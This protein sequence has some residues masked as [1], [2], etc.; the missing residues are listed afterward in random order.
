MEPYLKSHIKGRG[1][2]GFGNQMAV[3]SAAKQMAKLETSLLHL[4]QY[5]D[6]PKISL[7]INLTVSQVVKK[8]I[9]E[10]TLPEIADVGGKVED[11]TFLNSLG[12]SVKLWIREIGKVTSLDCDMSSR[13]ASQVIFKKILLLLNLISLFCF[14]QIITFWENWERALLRI[15]KKCKSPEVELT[16]NILKLDERALCSSLTQSFDT[17]TRLKEAFTKVNNYNSLMKD[18]PIQDLLSATTLDQI[19]AAVTKMLE[20]LCIR[21]PDS[22]FS[23]NETLRLVEAIS[24]DLNNQLLKV[25]GTCQLMHIPFDEFEQVTNQYFDV[26]KIWDAID[27]KEF[28]RLLDVMGKKKEEDLKSFKSMSPAHNTLKSRIQQMR[29]VRHEHEDLCSVTL[30]QFRFGERMNE[31][32][33]DSEQSTEIALNNAI[34]KVHLAYE[35][36]I[37]VDVFDISK[38]GTVAWHAAL[39]HYTECCDH[40]K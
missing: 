28:K 37:M 40:A 19:E 22:T 6:I 10:N 9:E 27:G 32:F 1:D 30:H 33:L 20:H 31:A 7:P 16:L 26:F 29:K 12:N 4:K 38:E 23:L 21:I 39:R 13:T 5:I 8:C 15:R 36:V 17:D 2:A 3:N 11:S 25:L 34:E 14:K 35:N 18:F 24:L